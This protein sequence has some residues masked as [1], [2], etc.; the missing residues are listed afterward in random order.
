MRVETRFATEDLVVASLVLDSDPTGERD[1]TADMQAAIDR[2]AAAGGG[3]V[4]IPAG[5]YRLAGSL[6][7][8]ESVVLRG[9]WQPPTEPGWE[10][11]TVLMVTHA[12]GQADATPTVTME[13]G[14][15]VREM[16][17]WYPE[18]DPE[19]IV[20][21]PWTFRTS[22]TADGDNTTLVN[23]YQAV[24]IGPEWNELHTIRNIFG[25]P[26]HTGIWVDF[27]TDI[28]RLIDVSFGP[29]WWEGAAL[30]G[31]PHADAAKQALRERL[32]T[33]ATGVD[34][35]RSDWEF[36]HDLSVG[37]YAVG[38]RF[39]HG[40]KGTTNAVMYGCRFD[41][42]G[43][44]LRI[45]A[46]NGI[47]LA[48]TGCRFGANEVAIHAPDSFSTV[49]QFNTCEIRG[50]A[51]AGVLLEGEGL[52]TFQNCVFSGRGESA[53]LARSGA[54]SVLG[55]RFSSVTGG[56]VRLG[57]AVQRARILGNHFEGDEPDIRNEAVSG[58]VQIAHRDLGMATA[59]VS[60]HK[61]APWP[62]P[63]SDRLW[64]VTDFGASPQVEDNAT[65][66]ARAFAAASE[67]GGG[68]VYVPAGLYRFQQELVVPTGVELRGC[69]D[70]PHHTV[71][72]GSVLL[73]TVGRDQ[74]EGTPFIRLQPGSG[75]RGLTFW[76]PEQDGAN[77]VAYPWCVQGLGPGCW[78]TDVTFGNAY[79]GVDFWSYPSTG[80][81]IRYVAGAFY[82]RGIFIS[83]SDGEGWVEDVQFNP[84]YSARLHAS[85][86]HPPFP[87]GMFGDV[88]NLQ[89]RQ[90]QGIVFGRC[91]REHIRGT[92]LYAAYDGLAFLD[93][94]GGTNARVISHGT[95]TG[96][97][98]TYLERVGDQGVTFLNAQLVPLGDH[99]EAAI[100]SA[101]GFSGQAAFFNTQVWAGPET[102]RLLG[103]GQVLIQ[104]MNTIS[105][106][107]RVEAGSLV[108]ENTNF[109]LGLDPHVQVGSG[110]ESV[111]LRANVSPTGEFRFES[112][113]GDRCLAVANGGTAYPETIWALANAQ[114][115]EFTTGWEDGE[116]QG[117]VDTVAESGGGRV[118]VPEFTCR[119]IE[120]E[121]ARS[122]D[123]V[124][125]LRGEA[126]PGR[127]AFVYALLFDHEI[128]VYPDTLV[129][130]WMRPV[131]DA[132]THAG[133]DLFFDQGA[134]LRDAG[135]QA[136]DGVNPHPASAKGSPG[137]WTHFVIPLG[138]SHS[139]RVIRGVMVGFD[140]QDTV[141][142]FEV[143]FDDL[144]ITSDIA[145]EDWRVRA[146]P[147]GG[148]LPHGTRVR[149][150][151]EPGVRVRYTLDGSSPDV[152]APLY[153]EPISLDEAGLRELKFGV[154]TRDGRVP[155]PFAELYDVR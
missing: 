33:Q 103:D 26:L 56:H 125:Q 82:R 153:D 133:V 148:P 63:E 86:P 54:L 35:G 111:L 41:D 143:W 100:V 68:T 141:E 15:G 28:G 73:V 101:P 24:K 57:E 91:E 137:T 112:L 4:F 130:Y 106:P 61:P 121:D 44:A 27:C 32:L 3:V 49:A 7:L 77:V 38:F 110:V 113:A 37:G 98:G 79:Q 40:E 10:D 93:D 154:E 85:L 39:R 126:E 96:S 129:S 107:V 25:T 97:R 147:A 29:E 75:L 64:A 20:P 1:T 105:G 124:L 89:R 76:Y 119:A 13:R 36:F 114:D 136:R 34:M 123:R 11:G 42:C 150:V 60:P 65:A 8:K 5:R 102:A 23:P 139:G 120:T 149:L 115:A 128:P 88:V 16:A 66:F 52:L 45:D 108:L 62:R 12:R 116:S 145:S 17:V 69:F 81:V 132:G 46:L 140:M 122:G 151:T 51:A 14:T 47:G 31:A 43:T 78:L 22:T 146:E 94:D 99:V 80:H 118:S 104:Q 6:V 144:E 92:F 84:H 134:P 95:D 109:A 72:A 74:E 142:E 55:S 58:D 9:D 2:V 131:T 83:K 90:L 21:Y 30:D 59:D 48:A 135:V 67:A 155:L 71:S 18:Q 127:H 19:N 87:Q 138:R 50:E 117:Y 53:I 152:D 70:V